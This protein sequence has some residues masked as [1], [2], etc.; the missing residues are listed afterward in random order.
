M[1]EIDLSYRYECNKLYARIVWQ[2]LFDIYRNGGG[3]IEHMDSIL[4]D[5][6]ILARTFKYGNFILYWSFYHSCTGLELLPGPSEENYKI[7][8]KDMKVTIERMR[9]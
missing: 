2:A 6:F 1:I 5:L 3:D 9:K 4:W 7:T 8:R